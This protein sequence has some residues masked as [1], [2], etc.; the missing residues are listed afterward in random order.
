MDGGYI[1]SDKAGGYISKCP[2]CDSGKLS[3]G[4]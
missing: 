4:E 1:M 2:N 3:L